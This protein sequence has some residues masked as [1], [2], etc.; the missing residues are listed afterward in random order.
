MVPGVSE[1]ALRGEKR[2]R[3]W[4]RILL[5]VTL[6]LILLVLLAGIAGFS[7]N[8]LA[9]AHYRKA[10]PVPGTTYV[11]DGRSMH[12]YCTGTGSPALIL[13][14]GLGDDWTVWTKVQPELSKTTQVC[15]YDRSGLGSSG[16]LPG[17]HDADT[18]AEQLHAL[19]G[20]AGIG[21]PFVLAGHSVAGLYIRA[22]AAKYPDD[23]AGLIFVDGSSPDQRKRLPK[24]ID[25]AI[26]NLF[27][28]HWI[29]I[30][31]IA[32]ATGLCTA[33]E[34]GLEE[35][36]GWIFANSCRPSVIDASI[37][38]F[39]NFD[40]SGEET[41]GTG[42]F[43]HLPIL[44]FS[45]DPD[46]PSKD[47]PFSPEVMKQISIAWNQMQEELK[48]LSSNS[49]RII[50]RNSGHYIQVDRADLVNREV[51]VFIEQIRNGTPSPDI[52][53]TKTE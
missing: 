29:T 50:A 9:T 4:R 40:R 24:E 14:A 36:K 48:R 33:T 52:G 15:S 32:R 7:W 13:D 28:Q 34:P 41:L 43:G 1:P 11:V 49:R 30:L 25:Q 42:P 51:P 19:V 31:G 6:G 21:K 26:P 53:T 47:T 18:V 2:R 5:N 45:Q 8:E 46:A 3:R 44:I 17:E 27:V 37:E 22:Y 10:Y 16:L 20:Q 38:E 23:L 39:K 12:I 35:A